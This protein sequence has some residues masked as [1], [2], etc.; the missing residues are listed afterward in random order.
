MKVDMIMFFQ[1]AVLAYSQQGGS[2]SPCKAPC[3]PMD[4]QQK[5]NPSLPTR[6]PSDWLAVTE[7]SSSYYIGKPSF[8]IIYAKNI[9]SGNKIWVP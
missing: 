4:L 8:F 9:E 3:N 5:P 2:H 7:F 1:E 6:G